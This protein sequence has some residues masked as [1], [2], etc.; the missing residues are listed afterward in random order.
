M[1]NIGSAAAFNAI[2]SLVVAGFFMSY[3]ISIGLL[4]HRRLRKDPIRWGPW[5]M[6]RWGATVNIVAMIYI[7]IAFFFSFFPQD[8][9]VKPDTMNWSCVVFGSVMI[10]SVGWYVIRGYK[11]FSGPIV[12]ID[13]RSIP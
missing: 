5:N 12:E 11:N 10:F 2:I 8:S 6:G 7:L 9:V 4:L 3:G 13:E 1:I